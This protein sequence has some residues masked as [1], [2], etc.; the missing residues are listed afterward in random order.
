MLKIL[1]KSLG[2]NEPHFMQLYISLAATVTKYLMVQWVFECLY[3]ASLS[4]FP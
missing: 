4:M 2:T 3:F 1:S